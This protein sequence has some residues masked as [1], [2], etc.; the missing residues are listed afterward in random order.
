MSD[1]DDDFA[2][3]ATMLA[4]PF[5][6]TVTIGRGLDTAT[7][8]AQPM[9]QGYATE[10]RGGLTTTVNALGFLFAASDYDF[11]SGA[12]EPQRGDVITRTIGGVVHTYHVLPPA[13][14]PAAEWAD[15]D[16]N[17]FFVHVK[18]VDP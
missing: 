11:G 12:V 13:R 7:V 2:A 1:F 15:P 18:H 14:G 3:V 10:G 9:L 6:V 17:Q 5:E 8:T 4:E 16:R